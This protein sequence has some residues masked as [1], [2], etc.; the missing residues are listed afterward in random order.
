MVLD[1]LGTKKPPFSQGSLFNFRK[2]LIEQNLDVRLLEQTVEVAR[3]TK[4]FDYKKLPE[5]L[6][7][8]VDSRP[9]VGAGRVEDTINLIGRAAKKVA[10]S[11]A[12]IL[13][14]GV[15][16]VCEKSKAPALLAP[17]IK[18][19]LD[20]DWND[21]GQKASG[22][23]A[24]YDQVERLKGWVRKQMSPSH[25]GTTGQL[26]RD[27]RLLNEIQE[28]DVQTEADGRVTMKQGVAPDR[29]VSVNDPEMR[30]GR[31]SK[32]KKFNGYKEH[33]AADLDSKLILAVAV[34]PANR[35]EDEAA[36]P[37]LEQLSKHSRPMGSIHVDRAYINS[38]LIDAVVDAEGEVLCKPWKGRNV[39]PG[40][41]LS[42]IHI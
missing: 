12:Q 35:P 34:T 14:I 17:S 39:D 7:V 40:L 16:K 41:Y 26:D 15:E 5:T 31:K 42:L 3:K 25:Q 8:A 21:S 38:E 6:R 1:C 23:Q 13:G 19:G 33:V 2:R 29:I 22:L 36:A 28:Q 24:L 30:H 18:S 37:L 4:K 11:A 20:L 10:K 9:L 32:S 27:I